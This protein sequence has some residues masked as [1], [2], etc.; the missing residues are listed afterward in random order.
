MLDFRGH[1]QKHVV[2][3]TDEGLVTAF[4]ADGKQAWARYLPS[5]PRS[6]CSLPRDAGDLLAVGCDDGLLLW[7]GA[8]GKPVAKAQLA[9]AVRRLYAIRNGL[10]L[11]LF[12]GTGT[13]DVALFHSL[14]DGTPIPSDGAGL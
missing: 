1:G 2:A 5:A 10:R 12:A 9:G 11:I 13:G 3:A 4:Q 8:T 7:I 6:L 14:P